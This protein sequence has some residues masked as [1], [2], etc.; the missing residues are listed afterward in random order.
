M[1]VTWSRDDKIVEWMWQESG[2]PPV[3][4]PKQI[5]FGSRVIR[6]LL[7][8]ELNGTAEITYAPAGLICRLQVPAENLLTS[9]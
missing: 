1:D 6:E 9:K 3:T 5:G 8:D 4:P 7:A 2:G